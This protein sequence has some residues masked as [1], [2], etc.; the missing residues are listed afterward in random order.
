[1]HLSCGPSWAAK[2]PGR[3]QTQIVGAGAVS[4]WQWLRTPGELQP[5]QGAQTAPHSHGLGG[6]F[7]WAG[8][9][10]ARQPVAAFRSPVVC[11]SLTLVPPPLT[12][13]LKL[14]SAPKLPGC[15]RL[16]LT[17]SPSG[18]AKS[19]GRAQ[20]QIVEAGAVSAW[21]WLRTPRKF[22]PAPSAQPTSS[23]RGLGGWSRRGRGLRCRQLKPACTSASSAVR[24]HWPHPRSPINS[25]S[26]LLLN[27]PAASAC[28]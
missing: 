4:A 11:G 13:P 25:N 5:S 23:A 28:I 2:S 24:S 10:V 26:R 19:P 27:C 1:M 9:F 17:F 20:T 7:G 16:H 6:W 14:A 18:A 22:Q 8:E 15:K 3:A 12:N 21:Q